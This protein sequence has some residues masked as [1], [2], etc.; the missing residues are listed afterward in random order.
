MAVRASLA[1]RFRRVGIADADPLSRSSEAACASPCVVAPRPRQRRVSLVP[2]GFPAL[3]FFLQPP[4][5]LF[6]VRRRPRSLFYGA[7]ASAAV[8]SGVMDPS[9]GRDPALEGTAES[10][11]PEPEPEHAAPRPHFSARPSASEPVRRFERGLSLPQPPSP[12]YSWAPARVASNRPAG[13]PRQDH[14]RSLPHQLPQQPSPRHRSPEPREFLRHEAGDHLSPARPRSPWHQSR[15]GRAAQRSPR[16]RSPVQRSPWRSPARRGRG[17]PGRRWDSGRREQSPPRPHSAGSGGRRG[18]RNGAG[19][20]GDRRGQDSAVDQAVNAVATAVRQAQAGGEQTHVHIDVTNGP[21]FAPDTDLAAPLRAP[22]LREYL[23]AREGRAPFRIPLQ[24]PDFSAQHFSLGRA[25][26]RTSAFPRQAPT[27][28]PPT[29]AG[30]DPTHTMCRMLNLAEACEGVASLQMAMCKAMCNSLSS[31]AP[32]PRGSCVSWAE[33]L[34]PLLAPVSV[35]P[36]GVAPLAHT[37]PRHME[38][39]VVAARDGT[40]VHTLHSSAQL[41][42]VSACMRSMLEVE[43]AEPYRMQASAASTRY[44]MHPFHL[45]LTLCPCRQQVSPLQHAVRII[46]LLDNKAYR[47]FSIVRGQVLR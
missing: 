43:G 25:P 21:L 7:L 17:S 28:P 46:A 40:P 6:G 30:R 37:L 38:D 41:L 11:R 33:A 45:V 10:A 14:G 22:T 39:L 4:C 35:A 32:G 1:V 26:G 20:G 15:R 24:V 31:Y 3:L 18:R 36:A 2:R 16:A 9:A 23:P 29:R 8:V 47:T 27:V 13:Q 12:E 19:R 44:L 42:A 34:V 5:A